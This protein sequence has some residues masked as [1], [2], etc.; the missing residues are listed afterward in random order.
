M[1]ARRKSS[2]KGFAPASPVFTL[3]VIAIL[4]CSFLPLIPTV[5]AEGSK[6]SGVSSARR[7]AAADQFARAE[8][9][10]AALNLKAPGKRSLADYK[11]V[12]TSYRR[13]ALI[14]PHAPEV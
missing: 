13:V 11:Q 7:Q 3:G 5:R 6:K 1:S 2:H 10:R 9:Q 12:V 8:D 14:T 4:G